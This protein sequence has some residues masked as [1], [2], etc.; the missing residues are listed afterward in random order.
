MDYKYVFEATL[1][2]DAPTYV[3]RWA[4]DELYDG[5][6]AGN[7]C[8]VFNSR[9]TGKSSLR[10]Q[11]M[12]E[13]K[14]VGIACTAIDLSR[15]GV[16][17]VTPNQWYASMLRNLM[18]DLELEVNLGSW[19]RER[20]W[21][22]PLERFREFIESVMLAQLSQT[23]V[24]F[25]DE[26]DSVLSLNFPTDDF[27]A[28]IR[29]CYNQRMD[30]PEYNRLTF[31][32]LG[33][34]TPSDLIAD[35][36]RTPFNIGQAI[37]LTGFKLEEAKT[38]L[39]QGLEELVDN[40]EAVLKE[41]LNWTGGQPFLTQKLCKL[42]VNSEFQATAESEA[43]WVERVVKCQIIE[44]WEFQD[45]PEHLKTIRNRILSS[46][47]RAAR[48]LGIY[49]QILQQGE[50]AA[51]DN[52]EQMELR[53]SGLV[54]KQQGSLRVYN[55]I[56]ASVFNLH[57]VDK[58][59]SDL[60]PYGS[61]LKAW[62][63]ASCQDESRLLRGQAL[64]DALAWAVGKSLS[65]LDYQFLAAS[66]ELDKR[67]VQLTLEAEKEAGRIL[68]EANQT[69]NHKLAEANH[70]AD[71]AMRMIRIGTVVLTASLVLSGVM[72]GLAVIAFKRLQ[73]AQEG[74]RLERAG[75][76]ALQQ[77][78]SISPALGKGEIEALLEALQAGQDLKALVKDDRPLE[79]YPTTSPVLAL[80]TILDNIRERNQLIGHQGWVISVSFSPDGKRIATAGN[81]GTVKLWDLEGNQ[82]TDFKGHQGY[83]KSVSFSPDGKRIATAGNDGTVR[84]WDL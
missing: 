73:E 27:F 46:E 56:Y 81:D 50:V 66:Q 45:E 3:K 16:Q 38:R 26:I 83:V 74:T 58:A 79:K 2:E 29:A 44:N 68:S 78:Q 14:K 18:K 28:F 80:Q 52:P 13:L 67:E 42:I 36:Q 69:A 54:V 30:N 84:L 43:E 9:K 62:V 15:S 41:V 39:V 37:E 53:L 23:I 21:L 33:V 19:W 72:S 70:K 48:L 51:D 25:I 63:G 17:Q 8:Y 5:L 64:Q 22:S 75:A 61:V 11:V 55:S 59:L 40:P 60:R 65:D 76:S 47:Q 82:L 32:L 31:C 57:W 49:Q 20:E 24:I 10:V 7:F 1:P 77:F 34:A 12:R 4:D 35:K 6:K 71:K